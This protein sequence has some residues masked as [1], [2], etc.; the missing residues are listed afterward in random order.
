M[1]SRACSFLALA[2]F[3]VATSAH[4]SQATIKATADSRSLWL[5]AIA[6]GG[7]PAEDEFSIDGSNQFAPI[8]YAKTLT[9]GGATAQMDLVSN[10]LNLGPGGVTTGLTTVGS[11]SASKSAGELA[12]V[13]LAEINYGIEVSG[14]AEGEFVLFRWDA[15]MGGFGSIANLSLTGPGVSLTGSG[16]VEQHEFLSLT[17]GT[18]LVAMEVDAGVSGP[19]RGSQAI[20]FDLR[21]EAVPVP[22][23]C[24]PGA[25]SCL[26]GHAGPGCN[27]SFCC[28]LVCT[29]DSYCCD[30]MW[31][32]TCA[33]EATDTCPTHFETRPILNPING[34]R[35]RI[36]SPAS[37]ED[38]LALLA[39]QGLSPVMIRDGADNAWVHAN[40]A[41]GVTGIGSRD[42]RL[43]LTDVETEGTF[44]WPN[45][46]TWS[47]RNWL[48]GEPDNFQDSDAVL[49]ELGTGRWT[50]IPT[51]WMAWGVGEAFAPACGSGGS[52][53]AQ[54]G[55]G[56]DDESCCNEMCTQDPFCCLTAWDSTC[57]DEAG[58]LCNVT[59]VGP[60]IVNPTTHHR[61]V[62]TSVGSWQQLAHLA[63]SLGGT[64][65]TIDDAAENEWLR[66]NFLAVPGAPSQT[67]IGL[68]DQAIEA[69]FQW[70][71]NE[72]VSYTNW[73][74]GEPNNHDGIEHAVTMHASGGWVDQPMSFTFP[75]IIEIP[76]AGDFDGNG[77]VGGEDL[78]VLLGSWGPNASIAD[79]NGDSQVDAADLAVLLG[80]WGPS[81]A[82]NA[83]TPHAGPGSD[84]PGCTTCV[85]GIDSFCCEVQWDEF[86]AAEAQGPCDGACQCGG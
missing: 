29:F 79:L 69:S 20:D 74:P 61:Y 75:A 52:C 40:L 32:E 23:S 15:S 47:Y 54:H 82:S 43:G 30:A 46:A 22:S 1:R 68:H 34:H 76:L 66:L 85:C 60:T 9:S 83:C 80:G 28:N 45:G 58:S 3:S 25:G 8:I 70:L 53:F 64:F 42:L 86:C 44:L 36:T 71:S 38:A 49:M 14:L 78:A 2:T 67:W 33:G 59:T 63:H 77:V 13:A 7:T 21:L 31:D 50:D 18:Y 39:T 41:R 17:N 65:A 11:A 27:D 72:P 56:C 48:P 16:L 84:Q 81:P 5:A 26:T 6:F 19:S 51:E 24:A 62:L 4:A 35:Y 12:A 55:P 73:L 37:Q 57:V 10:Y